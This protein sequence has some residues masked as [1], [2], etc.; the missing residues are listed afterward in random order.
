MSRGVFKLRGVFRRCPKVPGGVLRMP[1]GV[2][3][4][5]EG[6]LWMSGREL[7]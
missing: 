5:S 2:L 7:I 1:G 4:V 6:L 3:R